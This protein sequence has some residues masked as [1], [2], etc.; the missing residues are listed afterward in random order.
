[1]RAAVLHLAFAGLGA[2]RA[3]SGAFTDN[4]ASLGVSRKLGYVADGTARHVV[5]DRPV[6]EQRLLLDRDRWAAHRTVPVRI[7]G[8]APCR[9]LLGAGAGQIRASASSDSRQRPPAGRRSTS[10][11]ARVTGQPASSGDLRACR[12]AARSSPAD[13]EA[14][15]AYGAVERHGM[16]TQHDGERSETR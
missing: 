6:T 10:A 13:G 1:M 2:E 15:R 5:R 7:E 8:L 14:Q 4:A 3:R 16:T 12:S 9:P 11:S